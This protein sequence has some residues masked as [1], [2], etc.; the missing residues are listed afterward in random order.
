MFLTGPFLIFGLGLLVTARWQRSA[1]LFRGT[2]PPAPALR[3]T[4]VRVGAPV[5]PGHRAGVRPVVLESVVR[6]TRHGP[7]LA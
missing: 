6:L 3:A 5:T 2:F 7:D 4:P 1:F